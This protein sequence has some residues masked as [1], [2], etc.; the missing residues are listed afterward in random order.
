MKNILIIPAILIIAFTISCKKQRT[1][2]CTENT[3]VVDTYSNGFSTSDSYS[4][5]ST[6]TAQKQTKKFF[7]MHNACYSY[8]TKT[9]DNSNGYTEVR[10]TD[11]TCTLK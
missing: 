7:R 1:C 10:T 9:T 4:N 8:T 2:T 3:T 6:I 5:T 11:A